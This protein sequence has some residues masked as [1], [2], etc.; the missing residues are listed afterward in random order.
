MSSVIEETVCSTDSP[1]CM[2]NICDTCKGRKL[3]YCIFNDQETVKWPQWLRKTEL[4]EKSGKKV[5]VTKNVK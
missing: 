3:K 5:K 1:K 4:V 2:T